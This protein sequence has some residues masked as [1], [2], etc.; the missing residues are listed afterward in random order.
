[1]SSQHSSRF[2]LQLIVSQ[3]Q[4][5]LV[6]VLQDWLNRG[7]LSNSEITVT[8][9][10]EADHAELLSGL[11]VA[12][13][14]GIIDDATVKQLGET[15]FSCSL[16]EPKI[17]PAFPESESSSLSKQPVAVSPSPRLQNWLQQLWESFKAELSLQW[18]LLLGVFMVVVSSGVLVASQWENFSPLAQYSVLLSYTLV[19]WLVSFVANRR[20][21]LPLTGQ[22]LQTV[23]LLLLPVNFWAVTEFQ[24]GIG[25]SVLIIIL[26]SFIGFKIYQSRRQL[27]IL[28]YGYLAL[29]YLHWGW[30]VSPLL[31]IYIGVV[32]AI[33]LFI[34][35]K[36]QFDFGSYLLFYSLGILLFRG[37]FVTRIPVDQFGLAIALIAIALFASRLKQSW[38]KLDFIAI[39][40]F[41]LQGLWSGWELIPDALQTDILT[42]ITSLINEPYFSLF[43]VVLFPYILFIIG[44]SDW[45]HKHGKNQLGFFGDAIA[46]IAIILLAAISVAHPTLRSITFINTTITFGILIQRRKTFLPSPN[47][48]PLEAL[49]NLT[50][51]TGLVTIWSSID[52]TFPELS[53]SV[54]GTIAIGLMVS[55]W[56]FMLLKE[57]WYP[58][59]FRN[60]YNWQFGLGLATLSYCL[61]WSQVN[62][63]GLI[64]FITPFALTF[65]STQIRNYQ[66]TAQLLSTVSLLMIQPF[67]IKLAIE[68]GITFLMLFSFAMAGGLML[69]HTFYLR[70][71][72]MAI[73]T[74]GFWLGVGGFTLELISIGIKG[75]LISSSIAI[76]LLWLL[77][78]RFYNQTVPLRQLYAKAFNYWGTF[79]AGMLLLVLTLHS[80]LVYWN[81]LSFSSII[82]VTGG[83]LLGAIALRYYTFPS[84]LALYALG[85][86]LEIIV[87][88]AVSIIDSN[89]ITLSV[90]N[91]GLG[92][93]IQLLGNWRQRRTETNLSRHWHLIP[94]LYGGLGT[95]LRWGTFTR[96]SGLLTL[97]FAIILLGI[98]RRH[99]NFKPFIYLGLGGI[100]VAAYEALFYQ[101]FSLKTNAIGDELIFMAALGTTIIYA[102]RLLSPWLPSALNISSTT[103]KYFP[104]AHWLGSS[105]LLVIAPLYAIEETITVGLVTGLLLIQYALLQ[106]RNA[107]SNDWKAG[108]V[109]VTFIQGLGMKFYWLNFPFPT[110]LGEIF[111]LWKGAIF[112]AIAYFLYVFP[113]E[114]W[115]WLKRPWQIV[116]LLLPI[117]VILEDPIN[118]YPINYLFAAAFYLV[119][120]FFQ[121]QVRYSYISV[122]FLTG[123][124]IR[125]AWQFQLGD[126]L[127]Y[128]F[129]IALTILYFAQFDPI[130]RNGNQRS[131][132]HIWRCFG[133]GI[134]CLVA[135]LS[136]LETGLI[137]GI[138][139]LIIL[140]IGLAV[141]VRAFLYMGTITFLLNATYQLGILIFE[142]PLLK[143]MIGLAVG[144]SLIWLAATFET[145]RQNV[146]ALME[147]WLGQLNEWE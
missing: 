22:T 107:I 51:F 143:W 102:Y 47:F 111:V 6:L 66:R 59:L 74:V 46:L 113:W 48:L 53:F 144:I 87:A 54:W 4:P 5:E 65:I 43:S 19:F 93:A 105:I 147:N 103:F 125:L 124:T 132:R 98:G 14:Y 84:V 123:F 11:D 108:W 37:L 129:P 109:Y 69:V 117:I 126:P 131:L 86:N 2:Q 135:V 34:W 72:S 16:P 32:S 146:R 71:F 115:G 1:M 42:T 56:G 45:L 145:R 13:N 60:H 18:L 63:L 49:I 110:F 139:S 33:A 28:S 136:H 106:G 83:I 17:T 112:S 91:L 9:E 75:Y 52:A 25:I 122:I 119:P 133:T 97:G 80:F 100:S 8:L 57:T 140:L 39:L 20:G 38:R 130:F 29:G 62:L 138:I 24:L 61:F 95:A 35:Y 73:I 101:F 68:L 21:N 30:N 79:L 26:L 70:Q 15:S 92:I 81:F 23:A 128:V 44:F 104:D 7:L 82:L 94:L 121:Q 40:L 90:I 116:A 142:Y 99:D 41:G 76:A 134:I 141:K 118:Q 137:P 55:E 36:L 50:H 89:L 67:T 3:K 10:G 58:S 77:H 12:L 88:E 64:W 96:W 27:A 120:T 85:W 127:W 114:Q 31:T 78:N